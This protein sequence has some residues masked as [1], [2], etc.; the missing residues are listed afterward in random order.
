M[1][2]FL[3]EVTIMAANITDT[4]W[5]THIHLLLYY[6]KPWGVLNCRA[7]WKVK[8]KVKEQSKSQCYAVLLPSVLRIK[9]THITHIFFFNLIQFILISKYLLP[10][11][12]LV[13]AFHLMWNI[14]FVF[15]SEIKCPAALLNK[16]ETNIILCLYHGLSVRAL[17]HFPFVWSARKNVDCP[18]LHLLYDSNLP[19]ASLPL[20]YSINFSIIFSVA[21]SGAKVEKTYIQQKS[22]MW[23][24]VET[25]RFF[26]ILNLLQYVSVYLQYCW[27]NHQYH[28]HQWKTDIRKTSCG[29]NTTCFASAKL[30]CL[31]TYDTTSNKHHPLHWTYIFTHTEAQFELG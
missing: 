11:F 26:L 8:N 2:A 15:P 29:S 20:I 6:K 19:V 1:S 14:C 28:Q 5:H 12:P 4:Q 31:V 7:V 30:S 22:N 25:T 10:S 17:L 21:V 18:E 9:D 3:P 27:F 16:A 13:K 24:L 23:I